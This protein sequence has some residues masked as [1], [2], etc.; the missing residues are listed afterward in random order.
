MSDMHVMDQTGH[1]TI[2]WDPGVNVEV[3]TARDAF[4]KLIKGG[5]RAFRV[6]GADN[7]GEPITTFDPMAGKIM[8][9]PHLV[10]G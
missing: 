7:R 3:E 5:Y 9:V 6:E 4:K 1:S 10:G 2:T 8:M